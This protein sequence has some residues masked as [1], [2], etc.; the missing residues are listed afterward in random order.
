MSTQQFDVLIN[1]KGIGKAVVIRA[2]ITEEIATFFEACVYVTIDEQVDTEEILNTQATISVN[3]DNKEQR[4]F[5]GI[6]ESARF[7]NV[8][9]TDD[10]NAGNILYL[11]IVPTLFRTLYTK[12][13]RSFQHRS[14]IDIIL[15]VLKENNVSNVKIELQIRNRTIRDF[16]VQYGESDF[17][18]VSRLM[19]EEGLFYYFKHENGKDILHISDISQACPQIDRELKI[20]KYSTSVTITTDSVY[21]V[22]FSDSIGIKKIETYSY[23]Y[24]KAEVISG[25]YSDQKDKTK[26]SQKEVCDISFLDKENGNFLSKNIM[27]SENSVAK[28]LSGNSY[29][30]ELFPGSIFNISGSITEKHNG[31]FLT[32]S[33]KHFINQMPDN[34]DSLVYYNSFVAIPNSVPFRKKQSHFKNRIYGCQTAIVTGT[35]EEDIFC[36]SQARIKVKFHWDSRT[37]QDEN[38]SCWIRIAQSWAGNNF[39]ALI[40]PRVGM[41]VLVQFVNGDPDK[42]IVVGCLYNGLNKTLEY[43]EEKKTVSSFRTNSVPEGRGFNELSFNDKKDEEE[44]FIHAQKDMNLIVENDITEHLLAGAKKITLES[45]EKVTEHSLVIKK[46]NNIITLTEGDYSVTIDKGN[47][48]I[49]I[50]EGNQSV[51]LSN[52]NLIIDVNGTISIKSSKDININADNS[53]NIKAKN[54]SMKAENNNKIDCDKLE[55]K[56]ATTKLDAQNVSVNAKKNINVDAMALKAQAKTSIDFKSGCTSVLKSDAIVDIQ[57]SAG[58]TIGGATIKLG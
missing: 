29:C 32:I 43:A 5:S 46:G 13:Y 53:I 24:Q 57:G 7:E 41:E 56:S 16:C 25:S 36:D 21:N 38:S 44:I 47:Q 49:T 11:K 52:G 10:T 30:P 39:G 51:K 19:E 28:T 12:K 35:A 4:Y 3:V 9:S 22:S 2:E 1:C 14:A 37:Q 8:V 26:F 31:E 20:R 18:F 48:S 45:T 55:L 50:N 42:P 6:I 23:D 17:H 58:V 40:I 27:E 33:V 15:E 34:S 54:I